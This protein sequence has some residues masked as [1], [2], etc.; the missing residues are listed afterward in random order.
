M[1]FPTLVRGTFFT[2]EKWEMAADNFEKAN[3]IDPNSE[4]V[5][6]HLATCYFQLGKNEEAINALE[7][8]ANQT[9]T[10]IQPSLHTGHS[11]RSS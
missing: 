7:K 3:E 4:R 11:L 1:R 5:I 10:G 2:R 6:K 9:P 8:L